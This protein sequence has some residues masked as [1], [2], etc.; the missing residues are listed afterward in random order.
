MKNDFRIR[1]RK[2]INNPT[3]YKEIINKYVKALEHKLEK[4]LTLIANTLQI[5]LKKI[6]R[7]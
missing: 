4:N 6:E 2:L 7:A 1:R 3:K 5:S